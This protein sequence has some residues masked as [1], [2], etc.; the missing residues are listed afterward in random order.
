[1]QFDGLGGDVSF[2]SIMTQN[3]RN[4]MDLPDARRE[5]YILKG[6]YTKKYSGN[7]IKKGEQVSNNITLYAHWEKIK[8]DRFEI[9]KAEYR[10]DGGIYLTYKEIKSADGF[11]VQWDTNRKFNTKNV[12]NEYIKK[13][14]SKQYIIKDVRRR[15]VYYIKVRAYRIDS[16]GNRIYGKWSA[17][18]QVKLK[19]K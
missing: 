11:Q 13:R 19:N 16:A 1:M 18:K 12:T 2:N 6:W 8:V 7:L 10:N 9:C 5:G 14:L 3:K 4:L 17:V 15:E